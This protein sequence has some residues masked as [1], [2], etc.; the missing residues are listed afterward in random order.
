MNIAL[1]PIFVYEYKDKWKYQIKYAM[2][3][4]YEVSKIFKF[5]VEAKGG[6]TG[7]YIGPVIAHGTDKFWGTIGSAIK[8]GPVKEGK[9]EFQIRLL[10]GV[11]L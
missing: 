5:G 10:L 6:E 7:N 11:G 3:T 8:V 9:P 2:G 4:S 1:N